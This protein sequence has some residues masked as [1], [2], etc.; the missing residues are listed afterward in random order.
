MSDFDTGEGKKWKDMPSRAEEKGPRQLYSARPLA[1]A[2]HLQED[3][4]D[5]WAAPSYT[6][7]E[8]EPLRPAPQWARPVQNPSPSYLPN[9]VER[10]GPS[11]PEYG[12]TPYAKAAG[13]S[14]FYQRGGLGEGDGAEDW[15][16]KFAP[17]PK[18]ELPGYQHGA[19]Q[20]EEPPP[21]AADRYAPQAN[22]Y[23]TKAA[24]WAET[25]RRE[26]LSKQ[27][28]MYQVEPEANK[29]RMRRKKRRLRRLLVSL[30]VLMVLAGGAYLA[31]DFLSQQ[32]KALTGGGTAQV[33]D[34][35]M[36]VTAAQV[37]GYDP[38]PEIRIS[39]K[40]QVGIAA[41]SG[42]MKMENFAV[43]TNNVIT[44]VETD[45]GLY[46]YYL[47]SAV[48]GQLLGYYESLSATDFAVQPGDSFYVAQAPY[49]ING[50]GRALID[51]A[52]YASYV[53]KDAVLSPLMGGWSIV[54]SPDGTK[55][56]Y[57]NREG[58]LLSSLWFAKAFPFTG[59]KTV[60]Y[61]DTGNL[62]SPHER[63]TLYVLSQSGEME[64]W[65]H[66][67]DTVGVVGSACG[68]AYFNTGELFDLT[69]ISAPI[70][71][72]DEVAVYLDCDAMVARDRETGKY[73]LF[74][75]GEQHYDFAYDRIAPVEC[76]I[77]WMKSGDS[78]FQLLRVTEADY[79][80]PLS[81]YFVLQKDGGQEMV[82]LSTN[83]VY[84]VVLAD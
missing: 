23:Q 84:P 55:M 26:S 53:G 39:E 40:A 43:T 65:Q 2:P 27:K 50:K 20:E 41:V 16:S 52:A 61:V 79:P 54:K 46:D 70:L 34:G 31:R 64:R 30:C 9:E 72:S 45:G 1:S 56:N 51:S 78:R 57:V 81:H 24:T 42:T 37:R 8:P 36:A 68:V 5:E 18:F 22:V 10:P 12:E 62:A 13:P 76:D 49:L 82:A 3:I 73:G 29:P 80:Q 32:F 59:E 83:N 21:A 77:Q 7:N 25:A 67:S 15:S 17:P 71:Q 14:G 66:T 33:S 28:S 19:F 35:G 75:N 44:R 47:F 60:A 11:I 69:D 6:P 58:K 48:D 4:A 63:Y 74:V 38:A